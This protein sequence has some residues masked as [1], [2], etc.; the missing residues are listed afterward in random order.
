M[1]VESGPRCVVWLVSEECLVVDVEKVM[2]V[3]AFLS[4]TYAASPA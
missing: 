3:E 4:P 2:E 1:V